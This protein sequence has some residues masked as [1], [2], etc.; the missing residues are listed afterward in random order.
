MYSPA[1]YRSPG[2]SSVDATYSHGCYFRCSCHGTEVSAFHF[3]QANRTL[4]GESAVREVAAAWSTDSD[5]LQLSRLS[6]DHFELVEA[7]LSS[8]L[9]ASEPQRVT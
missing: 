9:H 3:R 8:E 4:I 2:L 6:F 7:V 5:R 1:S